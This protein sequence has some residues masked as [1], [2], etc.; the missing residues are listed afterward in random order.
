[1]K[2]L[3]FENQGSIIATKTKTKKSP[4]KTVEV[5]HLFRWFTHT[6]PAA[7][8]PFFGGCTSETDICIVQNITMCRWVHGLGRKNTGL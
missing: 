5:L 4:V 8:G 3:I 7:G 6:R 1:M 2:D